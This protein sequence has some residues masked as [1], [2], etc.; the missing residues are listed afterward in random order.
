MSG[1]AHA[2]AAR[3]LS[4]LDPM[5]YA[6]LAGR[7]FSHAVRG[8]LEQAVLWID[9]ARRSPGAHVLIDVIAAVMHGMHGDD[10]VARQC[11]EIARSRAPAIS[12]DDFF[13]AFP[14]RTQVR[15]QFGAMLTKY[16]F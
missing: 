8:E 3:A 5:L 2:D 9:R 7:A 11:A 6:M 4:P 15:E 12:K 16:G 1:Q 13:R 10:A 14:F